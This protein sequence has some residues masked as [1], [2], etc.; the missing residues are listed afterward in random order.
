MN[1]SKSTWHYRL[2][3]RWGFSHPK[4]RCP[5]YQKVLFVTALSI[6]LALGITVAS[7]LVTKIVPNGELW[8]IT[9]VS[10]VFAYMA[11]KKLG[12][13][14]LVLIPFFPFLI[15]FL[16]MDQ[17]NGERYAFGIAIAAWSVFALGA[18]AGSWRWWKRLRSAQ[19]GS[20]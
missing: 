14:A 5:Y 17:E 9:A 18:I 2:L 19:S 16:E 12:W 3:S 13:L 7:L 10:S 6:A 11:C 1:I 8:L 15:F 20:K 4:N